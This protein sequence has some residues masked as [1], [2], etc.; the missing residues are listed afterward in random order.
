MGRRFTDHSST[1]EHYKA[2]KISDHSA[3]TKR[4]KE[5]KEKEEKEKEKGE[6]NVD[7]ACGQGGCCI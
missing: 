3:L 7:C 4:E 1:I 2:D 5:K 6:S